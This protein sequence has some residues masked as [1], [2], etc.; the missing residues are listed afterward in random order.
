LLSILPGHYQCQ[1]SAVETKTRYKVSSARTTHIK[2]HAQ[3]CRSVTVQLTGTLGRTS[4]LTAR[5]C[6]VNHDPSVLRAQLN[7]HEVVRGSGL[8]V[9]HAP[10]E[11]GT[12]CLDAGM[13]WGTGWRTSVWKHRSVCRPT[14]PRPPM[15]SGMLAVSVSVGKPVRI[16]ELAVCL[17]KWSMRTRTTRVLHILHYA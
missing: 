16:L 12:Q 7:S 8:A 17:D 4:R 1:G 2:C 13:A 15:W 6:G 3:T 9:E 14:R 10:G 11:C 5:K